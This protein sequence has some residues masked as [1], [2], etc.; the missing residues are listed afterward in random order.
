[1]DRHRDIKSAPRQS[2][3]QGDGILGQFGGFQAIGTSRAFHDSSDS[4]SW[5]IERLSS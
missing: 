3:L 1:M 5:C 4:V 2:W